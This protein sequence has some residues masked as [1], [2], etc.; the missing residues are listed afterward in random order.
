MIG[1]PRIA[2]LQP[3]CIG[4]A[5]QRNVYRA[6][7]EGAV[8]PQ[9][10]DTIVDTDEEIVIPGQVECC[11]HVGGYGQ[12][13]AGDGDTRMRHADASGRRPEDMIEVDKPMAGRMPHPAVQSRPN[14]REPGLSQSEPSS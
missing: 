10:E 7:S 11:R 13:R 12:N 6:L 9:I 8:V 4:P 14:S 1:A 2:E 3:D 5:F